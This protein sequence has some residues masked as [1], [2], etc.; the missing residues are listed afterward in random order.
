[1]KVI[2]LGVGGAFTDR[3]Y[4]TNYLVELPGARLLIDA[5][6]TL[7]Y[8]LP[9]AGYTV[10]DITGIVLT[11][12]HSD[13]VGGLEELSQR[14]RFIY[15]YRPAIYAMPDQLPLLNSLFALHGTKPG[16]YLEVQGVQSDSQLLAAAQDGTEYRLEYYSTCGLH[17]EVTSSYIVAVHRRGGG[18]RPVRIVFT[19]DLGPIE[20][21]ALGHLAADPATAAIFHDCFTGAKPSPAHPSIEQIENFYPTELRSKLF[22]I[23]Y[24]DTVEE[25]SERLLKSGLQI[26][27]Q[28]K[29]YEW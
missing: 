21:S 20:K 29:S 14:C 26:A 6:T 25:V 3:F 24:A 10:K 27:Q 22:A 4:Q 2:P 15:Q 12:F 23:H 9:A 16:D 8:S 13:H 5:G 18:K 1:M 7:R 17:A 11:H 19:G 28:G